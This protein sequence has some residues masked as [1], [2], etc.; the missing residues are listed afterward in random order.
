M[1]S[2]CNPNGEQYQKLKQE[3]EEWLKFLHLDESK[4]IDK[5]YELQ[6]SQ[7]VRMKLTYTKR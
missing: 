7:Y 1:L 6:D 3:K 2:Y 4:I 5:I